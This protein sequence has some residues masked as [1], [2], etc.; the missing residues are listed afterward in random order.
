MKFQWQNS[1]FE[2][3]DWD[4]AGQRPGGIGW[5]LV[6]DDGSTI[7]YHWQFWMVWE[8]YLELIRDQD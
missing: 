8:Y 3:A 6:E 4:R 1:R 2:W 7:F 5:R